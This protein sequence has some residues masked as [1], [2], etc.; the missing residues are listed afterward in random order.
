MYSKTKQ[1]TVKIRFNNMK[2][3]LGNEI[4]PT[5]VSIIG[6]LSKHLQNAELGDTIK[7]GE[8]LYWVLK[9]L[10]YKHPNSDKKIGVGLRNFF[11]GEPPVYP[12]RC[13]YIRRTDGSVEDFSTKKPINQL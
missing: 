2:I 11:V 6:Y 13:F 3:K 5:K 7:E 4:F 12:G 9:D 10:L 1:P 8:E